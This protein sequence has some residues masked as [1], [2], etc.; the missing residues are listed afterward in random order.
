MLSKLTESAKTMVPTSVW[1]VLG[2]RGHVC[3]A[4]AHVQDVMSEGPVR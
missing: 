4:H 1:S 2:G 3:H